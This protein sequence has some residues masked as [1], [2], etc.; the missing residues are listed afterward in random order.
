[1]AQIIRQPGV[2]LTWAGRDVS[3]DLAPFLEE[4]SFTDSLQSGEGQ[5]DEISLKLDNSD[6]RFLNAWWPEDGDILKPAIVWRDE[7]GDHRWSL[8]EFALDSA[9][10][11][12]APAIMTVKGLSQPLNRAELEKLDN[13]SWDEIS[14]SALVADIAERSDLTPQFS[15]TDA[16]LAPLH[17]RNESAHQLLSRLAKQYNAS[18]AIKGRVLLFADLDTLDAG[19]FTVDWHQDM[20]GG[21]FDLT[22]RSV[23]TSATV[24]YYDAQQNKLITYTATDPAVD[25]ADGPGT[26]GDRVLKLYDQ[27]T[28]IDQAKQLAEAGLAQANKTKGGSANLTLFGGPMAA[29]ATMNLINAGRLSGV[30]HVVQATHTVRPG[31]GWT[32]RINVERSHAQ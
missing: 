31:Q 10:I 13:R 15:A 12:R 16:L 24:Q 7:A 29:G 17:Q 21:D 8:G 32:T 26:G 28:D 5:R 22:A 30:W 9:K 3:A 11:R 6:G 1:M 25:A 4:L 18:Y 2:A 27:A 20:E 14:L 23:Y 19:G